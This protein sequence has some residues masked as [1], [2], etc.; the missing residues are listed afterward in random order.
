MLLVEYIAQTAAILASE[1]MGAE[2]SQ[3][4][5]YLLARINRARFKQFAV[6][7]DQLRI[8]ANIDRRSG[9]LWRCPGSIRFGESLTCEAEMLF[10][11]KVLK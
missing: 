11:H 3:N 5:L 1:T 8:T 2:A 7:G 9:K 4:T 6:P 10:T